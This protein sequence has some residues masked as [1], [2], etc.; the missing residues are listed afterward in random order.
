M[1][2]E[3]ELQQ[4]G[5][6]HLKVR[7]KTIKIFMK[8]KRR[9]INQTFKKENNKKI[10]LV[11]SL[12]I[13]FVLFNIGALIITNALVMKEKPTLKEANPITAKTYN[14]QSTNNN[15]QYFGII[16]YILTLTLLIG[17]YILLKNTII[18]NQSYTIFLMVIIILGTFLTYDF[19]NDVGYLIGK[20]I[21]N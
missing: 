17:Y 21:F 12:F 20:I 16:F 15:A 11:D 1:I 8:A 5:Y 2:T 14:L 4:I 7:Q 13:L 10:L 18:N 3:F 19:L 9:E 6:E